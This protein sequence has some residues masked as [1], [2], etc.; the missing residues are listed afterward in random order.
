M[1]EKQTKQSVEIN[2]HHLW[3]LLADNGHK[4]WS[5]LSLVLQ[6]TNLSLQIYTIGWEYVKTSLALV[7][8]S[9]QMFA[10]AVYDAAERLCQV[11]S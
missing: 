10:I 11:L 1:E 6:K 2:I 5:T 4:Y 7:K 9:G 8:W 3:W